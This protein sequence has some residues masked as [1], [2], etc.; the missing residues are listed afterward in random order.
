MATP[1]MKE[2]NPHQ[3]GNDPSDAGFA[4]LAHVDAEGRGGDG[5]VAQHGA[6]EQAQA[7]Q[8]R[9]VDQTLLAATDDPAD[10]GE[11]QA[12]KDGDGRAVQA[13]AR[14]LVGEPVGDPHDD[15]DDGER[16]DQT[17]GLGGL[18]QGFD[19]HGGHRTVW[20]RGAGAAAAGFLRPRRS[21]T[22]TRAKAIPT[23]VRPARMAMGP[24]CRAPTTFCCAA[25][26]TTM[27]M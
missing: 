8:Q 3:Q 10:I 12:E 20:L 1:A 21:S 17:V 9:Q 18:A 5:E 26:A 23:A 14:E 24:L 16:G 25:M 15:T 11:Q 6:A 4:Q 22:G 7:P 13:P 2:E 27:G 19:Q